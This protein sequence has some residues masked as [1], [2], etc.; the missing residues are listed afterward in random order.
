MTTAR[1]QPLHDL[2]ALKPGIIQNN[3]LG[4][5]FKGDTETPEQHIPAMGYKDRDWETCMTMNDTWGF[6]SYDH[7]WKPVKKLLQNLV[8]IVSKGG[9][10]L[11]NVGPTCEGEIPAESIERLAA[12][13]RWM[14]V[15]GEAIYGTSATP[16]E[17]LDWGRCTKK[18]GPNGGTLFIHVFDWPASGKLLLPG[19]KSKVTGAK[20][21]AG[22]AKVEA[23]V[24]A[25]GVELSGLPA[26][27][28]DENASV[29]AVTF[30]G[31]LDIAK[32]LPTADAKGVI[33]L[34]PAK[35]D[36]NNHRG[37]DTRVEGN[38]A[39]IGFWTSPK[40]TVSWTFKAPAE[41]TY[42]VEADV[43]SIADSKLA[44]E[45]TGGAKAQATVGKTGDYNKYEVRKL[46]TVK[47]PAGETVIKIV[48]DAKAWQ[49]INIRGLRL[50]PA[51]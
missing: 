48:P 16:F 12:V 43:A 51:A 31:A 28:P 4:G 32:V 29:L 49:P 14:D 35:A 45:V 38:P 22:G 36:L 19:L 46:G 39:N 34:T 26:A 2:L 3:R 27:A 50:K 15:N 8:D 7:N 47:V 41:G 33:N 11:L 13:G 21:L 30:E 37:S 6:K 40:A 44:L 17:K 42:D 10:Y 20:L 5:G 24:N 23:S 9:N 1:A 25:D 18:V